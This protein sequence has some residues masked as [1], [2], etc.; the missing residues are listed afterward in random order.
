MTSPIIRQKLN[1]TDSNCKGL[2][3]LSVSCV[4][5]KTIVLL[6]KEKKKKNNNTTVTKLGESF[7][8]G[9]CLQNKQAVPV[10][11]R[12]IE[13]GKGNYVEGES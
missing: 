1:Y 8:N 10:G 3:V 4:S 11:V 2:G 12:F 6:G 13:R 9:P 5:L 7:F